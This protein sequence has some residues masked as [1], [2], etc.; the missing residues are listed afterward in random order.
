MSRP[1]LIL[2]YIS[3]AVL[4]GVA[5]VVAWPQPA[6]QALIDLADETFLQRLTPGQPD[7]VTVARA[8]DPDGVIVTC[9]PGKNDYP[10]IV[11]KPEGAVWDLRA[12]GHV[13]A[14]V[15]NTDAVTSGVSLRVDNEGDWTANPW[16][17][18][19]LWLKPGESG[20]VRVRF[21]YS[22]GNPGFALDPGKVNQIL[23]F[24]G[25]AEQEQSFRLESLVA[26]GAPGEKPPVDPSQVRTRPEGGAL[27]GKG[28]VVDAG[29]QLAAQEGARAELVSED[30]AQSLRVVLPAEAPKALV[31]IKPAV[32][33]WDL[34]DW[35]QVGVRLRNEG[36]ASVTP[37]ARLE[38]RNRPCPWVSAAAPLAPGAEADLALPFAGD[39]AVFG[40]P[41]GPKSGGSSFESDGASGVAFAAGGDGERVL[42]VV[43][44]TAVLPEPNMPGWLGT[45]PPV[46]GDWTQTLNEEFDAAALDETR[47]SIYYP[48]YWDKRA[49]FSKENV[50]LGDGVLR[51]RF[52][53][54]RGHAEDD[55]AKP[56]TDWATGFLT[57]IGKFRQR[58]G[59]FECRMKLPTA[60]G[61][62][63]AFWMMP[64]RGP[65][66]GPGRESTAEGG[67][68]FDILEFLTRY[69]PNRYNVACHWDGYGENHKSNG[70]ERIYAQPDREGFITAGLLWEPG[71]ATFYA[72]GEPVARWTD[73]RVASVPEYILF[74]AVS[75][76]WG[77]N[78]LTG[79]GLPD[80]FV[81]DYV[82]VWQRRDWTES[83]DR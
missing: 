51:L 75:G 13:E 66:A 43:S 65:E 58:Y 38:S 44:V 46:P 76:G 12:S 42:R 78:N 50:L 47:W 56:E 41:G 80:D 82:R 48:N 35:L 59:Y 4:A 39:T 79:E 27:L 7:Q 36:Q 54:K 28:V 34:R 1:S 19:T 16:N 2:S 32:G 60:S 21:G 61:L 23:V 69:G 67:M 9:R 37:Q 11:V 45:R 3:L 77:G 18:E 81:L 83:P 40:G 26:G 15:V 10:G 14:R 5:A 74:T 25:K 8:D 55:P 6:D 64:D 29:Q 62:W 33:M 57:S 17:S 52:E 73:D 71:Q 72:N 53:K 63:P 68:E 31:L 70:T 24:V 49:H 30:G 20:T 22:W